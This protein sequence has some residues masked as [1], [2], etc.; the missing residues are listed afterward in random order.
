MTTTS[1]LHQLI[2]ELPVSELE[3][4]R[5]VLAPLRGEIDPVLRAFMEAPEDDEPLTDEDIAAIEEAKAEAARG[6]LIPWEVV[7]A[8]LD[9]A[10]HR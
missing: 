10:G 2:D 1:E 9:A 7:E 6:E 8:H 5:S 3:T 4:A